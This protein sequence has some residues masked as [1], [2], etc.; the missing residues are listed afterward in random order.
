VTAFI[1]HYTI[2]WT[3]TDFPETIPND[4]HDEFLCTEEEVYELLYALDSIKAKWNGHD[5]ISAWKLKE[6]TLGITVCVNQ[7]LP[8]EWKITQISPISKLHDQSWKVANILLCV[9]QTP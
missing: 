5:N 2:T 4:R 8:K 3:H 7:L 6:S 1:T 9:E